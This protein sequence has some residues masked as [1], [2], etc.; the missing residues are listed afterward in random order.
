[1]I[2]P[3]AP[4]ALASAFL[5]GAGTPFAKL[6]VGS[7]DPWLL[8]GLLYLASGAGLAV[9]L[10]LRGALGFPS[11]EA[12]LRWA[13]V[14]WLLAVIVF[15]GGIAPVLLMLGLAQTAASTAS[16]L[17][18]LEGLA[19]MAI[20]WAVF[21]EN[22]DRR[23]LAGAAAIL[24]GAVVLTWQEGPTGF[25]WGALAIAGACI[26][27]GIDNNLTRK[28][29]SA[30]PIQIT[31]IKGIAAGTVNL[32][33]AL[34][35]GAALPST[36]IVAAAAVVGFFG[37]GVSLVLFVFALRHLGTAR[38]GAYFSIAPFIG[39]LLAVVLFAEPLT[40]RLVVAGLLM[41]IGV[42]IH[43]VERHEHTHAHKAMEH[44]HGHVHDEHHRH[45]HAPDDPPGDHHT[46]WHRHDPVAHA[47]PHYPD[48]H[49][50]HQH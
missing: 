14:P 21:R 5:F 8:A 44:E 49:H 15:G 26:A 47:H 40:M 34:S 16:L 35:Q 19:T 3:G 28:L 32:A 20:A 9:V 38:T 22:V 43:L 18:N 48:L 45:A 23:I 46:H 29:S 4:F 50:R 24:A 30:D 42:W 13:D 33:L 12:P 41:G 39:A 6:L 36:E 27:W 1:M 25:G 31:T 17:L 37:Y 2:W 11:R 10:A 7:V